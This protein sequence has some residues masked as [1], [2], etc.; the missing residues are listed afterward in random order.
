MARKADHVNQFGDDDMKK[1]NL[2][3]TYMCVGEEFKN[4]VPLG[5]CGEVKSLIEFVMLYYP[6]YD[7]DYIR[8][9]FKDETEKYVLE[10]VYV[11]GGKK[12]QA[13]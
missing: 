8:N 12:L 2:D 9:R 11:Y 1:L 3:K 5:Y 6:G 7:E 13:I 10:H 4:A